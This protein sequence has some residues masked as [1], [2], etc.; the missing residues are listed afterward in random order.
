MSAK[1]ILT[2]PGVTPAPTPAFS[3]DDWPGVLLLGAAAFLYATSSSLWA[4][5]LASVLVVGLAGW[6]PEYGVWAILSAIPL[7]HG[8]REV[9]T[10]MVSATE[11]A[12]LAA[13]LGTVLHV[14]YR[15]RLAPAKLWAALRPALYPLAPWLLLLAATLSLAVGE[16]LRFS[17]R[18]YRLVILEPLILLVLIR[19]AVRD[20]AAVWRLMAVLLAVGAVVSLIVIVSYLR[21][22]RV[23]D[24]GGVGRTLALYA[25]PNALALFL[26]RLAPLAFT[27]ALFC[28]TRPQPIWRALAAAVSLILLAALVLTFSRGAW[29][30]VAAALLFVVAVRWR[31]ALWAV[32]LGLIS[33]AGAAVV[34]IGPGR[35]LSQDSTMQRLYLWRS[36]LEMLRDHPLFGVG[37]DQFLYQYYFTYAQ[38]N[39]DAYREPY[40]SH[41]HNLVLDFWLR[42]GVLGLAALIW[43]QVG[44]W[45]AGTEVYRAAKARSVAILA[46]GLMAS[47]VDFLLHGLL[48]NSFFVVDLAMLFWVVYGAIHVLRKET[49]C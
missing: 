47:M 24:A 34:V 20:S 40:L 49:V 22:G 28:P 44:F 7:S 12:V 29:L 25:S 27:L 21:E 23:E 10:T 8:T 19:L 6:R 15:T 42:L 1:N 32:A 41:P 33:L 37:L 5:I 45:R 4:F 30:A 14:A 13:L 35:L 17:L 48:D 11:W 18:E 38:S 43:L 16:Y 36:A 31:R 3:F 26:G 46:L 9:G 39:P 2:L